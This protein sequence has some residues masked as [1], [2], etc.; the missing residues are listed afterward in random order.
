MSVSTDKKNIS[1]K[2]YNEI[3][4]YKDLDIEMF[5]MQSL[6]TISVSVILEALGMIKKNTLTRYPT[7]PNYK[8]YKNYILQ[9]YSSPLENI[10]KVTDPKEDTKNMDT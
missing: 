4:I 3:S 2:E 5:K 6:K 1:I 9:N 8:K 7:V 10:T